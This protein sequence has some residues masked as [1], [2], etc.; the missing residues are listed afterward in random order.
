MPQKITPCFEGTRVNI[1]DQS[2]RWI[3]DGD[4]SDNSAPVFWINGLAGTRKT[5]LAYTI[6]GDCKRR[7]IPV[8]SF[9]CSRDFSERSN[10]NLIFASIAHQLGR[11]FPLFREKLAEVLQSD[12]HLA[13][14]SVPFQLE[15]L[16]I[17]PLQSLRDSFSLCLVVIDALDE[18]KDT[19]TTSIILSS[20]TRHVLELSPLKI[21]VTSRPE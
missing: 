17:K 4:T 5:T 16:I 3:N 21:L 7:G 14:A 13:S 6:A 1:L 12:P 20:L 11:I 9:F 10:P 2:H 19:G 15:E 18:C 8:T